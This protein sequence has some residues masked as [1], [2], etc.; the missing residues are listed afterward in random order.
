MTW[1]WHSCLELPQPW[2]CTDLRMDNPISPKHE[3]TAPGP[4]P[5][6]GRPRVHRAT[7]L[8]RP[9]LN[10]TQPTSASAPSTSTPRGQSIGMLASRVD[11]FAP[12]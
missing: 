3:K 5:N 1:V 12:T 8:A 4:S 6:L 9:L 7:T 2:R 11:S 10:S